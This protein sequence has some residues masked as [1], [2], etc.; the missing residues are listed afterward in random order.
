MKNNYLQLSAL[1]KQG[2]PLIL[3]LGLLLGAM[4][5]Q[6]ATD[7]NAVTEISTV[8]CK[9][10]LEFYH[11][12]NGSRW[13]NNNG[14]NVTNIPCAWSGIYC[15]N[16]GLIK[17]TLS[18]NQ[19]TG[20]IPDFS[21]LPNLQTLNLSFNQLTGT[22]PDFS[23]LPNLQILELSENQLTGVIPN[24]S[25]LPN[26]QDFSFSDNQLTLID[27]NC[28]VVTEISKVECESLLELYHSTNGTEWENSE[29]WNIT[30]TPCIWYGITCE[31]GGVTEINLNGYEY[32]ERSTTNN[33]TG[34]LPNFKGLPNLQVLNL[35]LNHLTG[36]IPDF[37]GLP[38]L[39]SLN[40]SKNQLTGEIPKF[41]TLHN[42]KFF[43]ISGNQLTLIDT[44][45]NVVTEI[46]KI[47]CKSLLELYH[48]TNG[49]RWGSNYYIEWTGSNEGWNVTNMPCS[50]YGITCENGGVTKI[51]L[52]VNNLS[53]TIPDFSGLLNLQTLELSD[54]QLTGTIPDLSGLPNLQTLELSNNQ[55][56]GTIPDFSTS[57]NLKKLELFNNQFT[58]TI[59]N[60]TLPQLEMFNFSNNQLTGQ[61]PDFSALSNLQEFRL[62]SNQLTGMIPVFNNLPNLHYFSFD[63]NQL[64]LNCNVVTE[65]PVVEC[66]SLL[67]FY[68]N[69]SGVQWEYEFSYEIK[70]GTQEWNSNNK[71]CN[72]YGMVCENGSVIEINLGNNNQLTGTIP[73]FSGLPNLQ[74]LEL[75]DNKLTGTIPDFSGLPNLQT[76]DLSNNQ[77]TGTIPDF[78]AL[79]NLQT[80]SF[81]NNLLTGTIPDFSALPNLKKLRFHNKHLTLIGTNCNNVTQISKIECESLLELYNNTNGVEWRYNNGWNVTNVPCTWYGITCENGG[82]IEINLEGPDFDIFRD[83]RLNGIIPNFKGLPNLQKLDLSDNQLMGTIPNFSALPNLHTLHLFNNNLIGEIPDFKDLTRLQYLDLRDNSICKSLNVDYSSW[84]EELEEF[85]DCSVDLPPVTVKVQLNQ[86]RYT[87]GKSIRLDIQIDG[88]ATV[89][90]YVAIVFPNGDFKTITYPLIF[91][92][93]NVIQV[94]KP[95][96]AIITEQKTYAVMNNFQLPADIAKGQYQVYG[97][98]VVVGTDPNDRN[99]WIHFDYEKFKVY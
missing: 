69:N 57:P 54:N 93:F 25:N 34:T 56:T 59:P 10:L 61:L 29:G 94:Y 17:I 4:S 98:L 80:L 47:E 21:A 7:C 3:G 38:N 90:L 86:N 70:E 76:L 42:L 2:Y 27:T 66:E 13:T 73:D 6:A 74:S 77:L 36:T 9:S 97:V 28:N 45:C 18:N 52:S 48:S 23:A 67:E 81:S 72:W 37:S 16:G 75:D 71:P 33:L 14:W 92:Q 44:N 19:L 68:E 91:S 65:I 20:T 63:G 22:I 24:F 53:G 96:I 43:G 89:D 50:W 1:W 64:R 60:F 62:D 79:P 11:S 35:K 15:K 58:G 39:Q 87:T 31:N 41:S 26:L 32:R 55:L 82:V 95:A 49:V 5:T 85:P 51:A 83:N 99:N 12:T 88:Q 84:E 78:S 46:S 40:L 30:N 8:E